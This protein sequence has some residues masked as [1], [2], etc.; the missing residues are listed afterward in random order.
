MNKVKVSYIIAVYNKESFIEECINSILEE[1]SENIEIEICLVDDGSTDHSLNILQLMYSN[2]LNIKIE[3]FDS[4]QGK[5]AAYNKAFL[6]SSGDYICIFGADDIVVPNRTSEL[7]KQSYLTNK[8]TYG[9]F[10]KLIDDK[11]VFLDIKKKLEKLNYKRKNRNIAFKDVL[12]HN[13]LSG[14]TSLIKREHA[15]KIFPIPQHLKFEDWWVSYHLTKNNWV[16]ASNEV[17]TVYRIHST[18]DYAS[19]ASSYE[20]IK[21]DYLRH[22]SYLKEFEKIASS[23]KEKRTLSKSL[24]LRD[25][26]FGKN[27]LRCSGLF[28]L[29]KNS[30]KIIIFSTLGA[31]RFYKLKDK[32]L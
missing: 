16:V 7:L 24:S 31:K 28:P 22:Y 15:D 14:G 6:M 4:N 3:N 13:F 29:D 12:M 30:I 10:I 18:N 26:F 20:M 17:V 23:E 8:S 9:T 27:N 21:R 11:E 2:N 32:F 19:N 1:N 25:S 5:N